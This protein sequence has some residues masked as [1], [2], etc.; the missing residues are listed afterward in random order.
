[1]SVVK[2]YSI[3]ELSNGNNKI[4]IEQNGISIGLEIEGEGI[5]LYQHFPTSI[6]TRE[7][8]SI[9]VRKKESVKVGR[10]V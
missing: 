7:F 3:S 4:T 1:M 10:R 6:I 5:R 2:C 9:I 8:D